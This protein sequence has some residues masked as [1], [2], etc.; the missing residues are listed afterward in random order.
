[1]ELGP[2]P[3]AA[4]RLRRH[5]QWGK[6]RGGLRLKKPEALRHLAGDEFTKAHVVD[7]DDKCDMRACSFVRYPHWHVIENDRHLGLAVA[8]PRPLIEWDCV[9]RAEETVR[10]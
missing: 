1:M 9:V 4:Q 6:C 8:A 2:V 7:E 10:A 5:C 3:G